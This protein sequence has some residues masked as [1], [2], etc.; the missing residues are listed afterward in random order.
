MKKVYIV[1]AN[2]ETIYGKS[3]GADVDTIGEIVFTTGM[4]GYIETLTDPSY[5]GQIIVQTFPLIGN[6]G[7]IS[8][9][10][11]SRACFAKGYVVRDFCDAP[12]NFRCEGN[13][14]SY[15]KANNIPGVYDVDTRYLTK[16]IREKGVMNA[17]ITAD[18]DSVSFE[19]LNN[20]KIENVLPYVTVQEKTIALPE[21]EVKHTVGLI[22]YGAKLNIERE[23]TKR[24][25]KVIIYPQNTKAE[26]ILA[27][28]IEGIMLS[29]GPGDPAVY[30]DCI[31]ELKKFISKKPIF[32][33]CLG[34]QLLALANGATTSKLRYGHRGVN[35]P[36]K[37]L[38]G[39]RTFITTQNHGYAVDNNSLPDGAVLRYT[40]GN[41]SSCEGIDYTDKNAFSVQFHPEACAGPLDTE[42]LFDRFI[43]MI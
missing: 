28:N 18:P 13:L 34:H 20:Y 3:F 9:D 6:Y 15:L 11:E 5:Y 1:L 43:K 27:D 2:G 40:N 30:T 31:T 32:G 10:F 7:M 36:V 35:H 39:G 17:C 23:L 41:D 4:G 25:C 24:G 37:D 16:M 42:F 29:N 33:I 22:D 26:E 14:D 12:S 8:E 21:G 38:V 19:E